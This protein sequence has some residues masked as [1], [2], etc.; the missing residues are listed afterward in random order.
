MLDA[1]SGQRTPY[2]LYIHLA[3]YERS[4]GAPTP[5]ADQQLAAA[6]RSAEHLLT[7]LIQNAQS[8]PRHYVASARRVA[9]LER[10]QQELQRLA[11]QVAQHF[12]RVDAQALPEPVSVRAEGLYGPEDFL[13]ASV[14]LVSESW[15]FV[16]HHLLAGVCAPLTAK[17]LL[18]AEASLSLVAE[19][20]AA[21]VRFVSVLETMNHADYHYLRVR[22]RDASGAQSQRIQRLPRAAWAVWQLFLEGG[23]PE[24]VSLLSLLSRS[25]EFPQ[26]D[27]LLSAFQAVSR[28]FQLFL[29]GHY[30]MVCKILG[31]GSIGS[32]GAEVNSLVG[33]AARP[34][35]PELDKAFFDYVQVTNLLYA[36]LSGEVVQAKEEAA[37][38]A[39][40]TPYDGPGVAQAAVVQAYFD[41]IAARD[42]EGWLALF[43]PDG[44]LCDAAGSRPFQGRAKLAVFLKTFYKTFPHVHPVVHQVTCTGNTA[45]AT[46]TMEARSYKDEPVTFSGT[47][48]FVFDTEGLIRHAFA[49]WEPPKLAWAIVGEA[50][51]SPR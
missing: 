34:L 33:H 48:T 11:G 13:F 8:D 50:G 39:D 18:G 14:H 9:Q 12:P 42:S 10:S 19:I 44:Q 43:H 32:L 24:G 4:W 36:P 40:Y 3:E 46:W 7:Q 16:A 23:L 26:H 25:A 51:S 2:A 5:I 31:S 49:D 21:Q 47:E 6:L 27:A 45:L 41:R 37:Q 28:A 15:F 1:V 35:F 17:N 38:A 30:L 20:I 29:F 22:L